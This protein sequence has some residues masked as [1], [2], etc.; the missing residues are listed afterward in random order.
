MKYTTTI[1][2]GV[3]KVPVRMRDSFGRVITLKYEQYDI[4]VLDVIVQSSI[5]NK[6][7]IKRL[8]EQLYPELIQILG[9]NQY[10]GVSIML[11]RTIKALLSK[12]DSLKDFQ[13]AILRQYIAA[14]IDQNVF[15]L[16]K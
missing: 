4:D 12:N 3:H 6:E 8:T 2:K 13:R 14:K 10:V 1:R 15:G 11:D 16:E 5:E 9:D 7:D